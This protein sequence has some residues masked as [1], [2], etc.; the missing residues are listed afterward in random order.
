MTVDIFMLALYLLVH[1]I[2]ISLAV[3]VGLWL[4][5]LTEWLM[6][7]LTKN[8]CRGAFSTGGVISRISPLR[9]TRYIARHGRTKTIGKPIP[10]R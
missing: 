3:L 2:V 7:K 5:Y 8:H 4:Y 10:D 1:F 6:D 9:Q